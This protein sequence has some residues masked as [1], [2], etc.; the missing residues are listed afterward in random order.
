MHIADIMKLQAVQTS[1]LC[2]LP[3]AV[4][5]AVGH[6]VARQWCTLVAA[7]LVVALPHQPALEVVRAQEVLLA[8]ARAAAHSLRLRTAVEAA[9]AAVR[10]PRLHA[11]A[12]AALAA[13]HAQELH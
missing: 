12:A 6:L 5:H 9:L 1:I 13:A 8:V 4:A 2:C 11:A 3:P 7:A 10:S